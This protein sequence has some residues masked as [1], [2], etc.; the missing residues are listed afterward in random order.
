V[1][2]DVAAFA[3][4]QSVNELVGTVDGAMLLPSDARSAVNRK[5]AMRATS[6]YSGAMEQQMSAW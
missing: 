2:V 3:A 4:H 5:Y 1:L 6:T